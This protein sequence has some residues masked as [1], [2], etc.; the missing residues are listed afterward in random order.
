M[1]LTT[2]DRQEILELAA[3]YNHAIDA[4]DA[5]AWA[6]T[7]TTDGVFE[8]AQAT[9]Q[10]TDALTEFAAGFGQAVPGG[11]HWTNNHVVDGDGDSAIHTCY[12]NLMSVQDGVKVLA[13]GLY[14]D[15][16]TKL[17]GKW[18]YTKRAVTTD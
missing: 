7:F 1:G 13:T 18:L 14:K 3:R 12:L 4:G 17:D 5:A 2:E 10:G 16:L 9:P 6:A 8:S 15:E 11:R